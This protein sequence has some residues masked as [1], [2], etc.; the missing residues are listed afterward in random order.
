MLEI[1][2]HSQFLYGVA[3]CAVVALLIAGER[4]FF[5]GFRAHIAP[6]PF[7]AQVQRLVL[8]GRIDQAVRY[9]AA[10]PY[11]PLANVVRAALLHADASREDM[12]LAVEQAAL[13]AVP[14]VQRRVAYLATI[15]NVVTLIGL[16]G[17]IYGLITAFDA[18]SGA[19]PE[20]KQ[21]LLAHGIAIAMY[22]T[23]GGI[24]V[25]IP[26]LIAYAMLVQRGNAI[27]DDTDRFGTRMLLL[28]RARSAQVPEPAPGVAQP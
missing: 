2:Q 19:N 7:F 21:N 4:A 16:L 27:L 15:A 11:A 23:A 10:E 28:L 17:T 26:C 14:A 8:E 6:E 1:F 13:D 5:L 18:V 20:E 24:A 12:A 22:T 3:V 25:A 9:C